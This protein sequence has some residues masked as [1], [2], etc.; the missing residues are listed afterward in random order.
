MG[1]A[2]GKALS[3]K[4]GGKQ[5]GSVHPLHRVTDLAGLMSDGADRKL[6]SLLP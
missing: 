4:E 2:S 1:G 6:V 5:H 3:C